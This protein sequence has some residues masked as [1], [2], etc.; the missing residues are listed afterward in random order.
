MEKDRK[1]P[2]RV[3]AARIA[4]PDAFWDDERALIER[5]REACGETADASKPAREVVGV[6]LSGGG[7]RS[8]TFC[9]G[10]F[11]GLAEAKLLPK[12][13]LLSTV[14]GGGYFG[15]FF[16]RLFTRPFVSKASDVES[17][18]K[19]EKERDVLRNLRENGRYLAPNGSGDVLFA[20]A[21]LLRN[22][23]ALHVVLVCATITPFL[24]MI[25][26]VRLAEP[27]GWSTW[28]QASYWI[29][30]HLGLGFFP[31]PWCVPAVAILWIGVV[32]L[33]AAYWFVDAR[34]AYGAKAAAVVVALAAAVAYLC[35]H[36]NVA[37]PVAASLLTA[38]IATFA[39]YRRAWRVVEG[40]K[41]GD[42]DRAMRRYLTRRLAQS[43]AI[44]LGAAAFAAIDT[45]GAA[46]F[47]VAQRAGFEGA[48]SAFASAGAAF[49]GAAA[50]AKK[51]HVLLGGEE[52]GRPKIGASV[53]AWIAAIVIATSLL[54]VADALAHSMAN[55]FRAPVE[56][57]GFRRIWPSVAAAALF[58]TLDAFFSTNRSFQ[59]RSSH[60][61][62][63][64][65]RI[66]RAYFGAS[67]P[68]RLGPKARA[69]TETAS[70]DDANPH[71]YWRRS[72]STK[73]RA[74]S[75]GTVV[76]SGAS[77][78]DRGAPL[79]FVN[80]TVNETV[81]GRSQV[82]QQDRKGLALAIGP[83]GFSLGVRHHARVEW[84]PTGAARR[85]RPDGA[86]ID[87]GAERL[88]DDVPIDEAYP[89]D[90]TRRV[91]RKDATPET[92]SLG[93]WIGTSGAAFSTGLGARTSLGI[94]LLLGL[95]NIR[96][97]YWWS[98][99]ADADAR[100][101]GP[102]ARAALRF[103]PV[104]AFLFSEF[105]ARFP[106]TAW[107][108]WYLSDGGH[109]ENMGGYELI[110]RRVRRVLIVDAEQ[111]ADYSYEGLAGLVRKARTDFDAS[112]EFLSEEELDQKVAPSIR[113]LFGT[114]EQLRRGT[115]TTQPGNPTKPDDPQTVFE[116]TRLN[117]RSRA[118]CA[119]AK[120]RYADEGPEAPE[121]LL[122]YVK[123]TLMGDEPADVLEYHE[124]HPDFPHET[125][126]DQ[127]FDEAQ[128]ES[129]RSLGRHVARALFLPKASQS[130][131]ARDRFVPKDIFD[132]LEATPRDRAS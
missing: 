1:A 112:I 27:L 49:V 38:A 131:E 29:A 98:P 91:F 87:T 126:A 37:L 119:L 81:D 62:L 66:T 23:V 3:E 82:Q 48:I 58:F 43:L 2:G 75:D 132:A 17:I 110:R 100:P 89:L 8:A 53:L 118:R 65:D 73:P 61:G 7:V 84:D 57:A 97:G 85:L 9:L 46:L 94:S 107:P 78:F 106:G 114:L 13:D 64:S 50:F 113:K 25:A 76:E 63:Y 20:G 39:W 11:Q 95:A 10:L 120:I 99:G 92:L 88:V 127:F 130:E 16:C 68:Q 30:E 125:T 34:R 18:L 32:P 101:R 44:F 36:D 5:R 31:S 93:Y 129:Y 115:W 80:V 47:D 103:F 19:G 69:L 40:H 28:D 108:K 60:H 109:F 55:R 51:L 52:S 54:V 124:N 4:H 24:A 102:V 122:L 90:A 105:T 59:N 123:P 77:P 33:G 71:V 45:T 74:T 67:N 70:G 14:S 121:G 86:P 15:S 72:K 111:D 116:E 128:W 83:S 22:W 26:L 56:E 21:S 41:R 6:G 12:I 35:S 42:P 117:R 96:L 104:Q 79:H